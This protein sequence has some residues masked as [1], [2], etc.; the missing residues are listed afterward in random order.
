MAGMLARLL[1]LTAMVPLCGRTTPSWAQTPAAPDAA[2]T[3]V[4]LPTIDVVAIRFN[5][6]RNGLQPQVGASSYELSRASIDAA[7]QGANAPLNDVL[8]QAPGVA[9]DSFGQ[10]HVRGDHANLQYRINGITIPE[11]ISGF[12]QPLSAR[13]VDRITLITGALPAQYGYRT[14]GVYVQDEW[15][16]TDRLTINAGLRFDQMWQYVDANQLSPRINAVYKLTD[17]T[18]LHVGYARYFTPPPQ[19]LVASQSLALFANTTNAPN[20]LVNSPVQPERDDY[21]DIGIL[22]K[23]TPGLQIG[24]DA[25]YKR[26]TNLLD[27]GQFGQALVF[28]PFNYAQGMVYGV[29]G[30]ASYKQDDLTLYGNLA[31]SRAMGKNIVSGQFEFPA[32]ELAYIQNH[33][34]YLDHDQR[35]TASAGGSYKWND[36]TFSL[37]AIYGSGLRSGF[38]NTQSLPPYAQV[39]LGLAHEFQ[40]GGDK[41]TAR[42]DVINLFDAVYEL[43][44]GSGIGV[45][46]PQ[47]GPRRTV[48]A[49]LTHKF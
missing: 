15:K 45:G 35:W 39:N 18:T 13:F 2:G 6:A 16:A 40:I 24:V 48:L 49:G 25:Y 5:A 20:S 17:E 10:L 22:H 46:A 4:E 30:T 3:T 23:I 7:P 12:G 1:F 41:F 11:A 42:L 27:E 32:A 31:W 14:A 8:L 34:V 29:E 38:A 37:S 9:Q 21:F 43:R 33:W 47:W 26:A 36:T 19:E 28:S 44:D